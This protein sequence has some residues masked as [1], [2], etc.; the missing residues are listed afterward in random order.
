VKRNRRPHTHHEYSRTLKRYFPFG[1]S[2]LSHIS[3]LDISQK[4]A[5]LKDTP[6]QQNHAAVYAKVFF[7]W[8]ISEGYQPIEQLQLMQF[9][10]ERWQLFGDL[11]TAADC[12][13]R[14]QARLRFEKDAPG[15]KDVALLRRKQEFD[16]G[17]AKLPL[18]RVIGV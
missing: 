6:S 4:L 12:P 16:V 13:M 3:K 11:S 10:G 1:N 7:N 14:W 8:A 15:S 2:N 17:I 18:S 5:R 9:K